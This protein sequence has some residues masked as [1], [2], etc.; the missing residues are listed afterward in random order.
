MPEWFDLSKDYDE[1]A[2]LDLDMVVI[3]FLVLSYFEKL[4]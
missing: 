2:F 4:C 1:Q 3:N